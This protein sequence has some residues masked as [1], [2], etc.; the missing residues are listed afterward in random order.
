MA[1]R[2]HNIH[3]HEC[4]VFHLYILLRNQL[5]VCLIVTHTDKSQRYIYGT[6]D[7]CF[8]Y[9]IKYP[10]KKSSLSAAAIQF[11]RKLKTF[12]FSQTMVHCTAT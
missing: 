3:V 1:V 12:T 7:Q 9:I 6:E 2:V 4:A 8:D 10:E 11:I 5:Q